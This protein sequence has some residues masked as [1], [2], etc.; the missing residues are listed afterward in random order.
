MCVPSPRYR[1]DALAGESGLLS[2]S[3]QWGAREQPSRAPR[4]AHPAEGR[5]GPSGKVR[6]PPSIPPSVHLSIL[7]YMSIHPFGV[8]TLPVSNASLPV[9]N[10]TLSVADTSCL[11]SFTVRSCEKAALKERSK[12]TTLT[13]TPRITQREPDTVLPGSTPVCRRT[14]LRD[15]TLAVRG[16]VFLI[17]GER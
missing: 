6:I 9:S 7:P 1:R 2:E 5:A 14:A 16:G 17:G 3:P 4:P 12:L 13:M 11:F 10:L 15:R 8:L